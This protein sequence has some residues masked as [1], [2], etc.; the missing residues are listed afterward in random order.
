[1]S[2]FFEQE[3]RKL[4]GD[5]EIIQDPKFVGRACLGDLGGEL[6]VRAEF[7]TTGYADHYEALRLVVLKR[8][9]GEIDRLV[10]RMKDVIGVKQVPGNPN[11]PKGVSPYIWDDC[12]KAEWYAF[13]PTASDYQALRRAITWMCSGSRSR[14]GSAPLLF[15]NLPGAR[16]PRKGGRKGNGSE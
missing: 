13:R 7:I 4:F 11:F 16:H 1:M 8:T 3:L 5:G 6:L 14:S 10:L 2:N 9:E 15:A 12:G